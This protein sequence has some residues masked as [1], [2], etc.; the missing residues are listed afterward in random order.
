MFDRIYSITLAPAVIVAL[1]TVGG[2]FTCRL[3]LFWLRHPRHAWRAMRGTRG[4]GGSFRAVTMALAGTLGVGNI[5]GVA[6]ALLIGGPG[7]ILWMLLSAFAAMAVK[8]AEVLLAMDTRCGV[9]GNRTGGAT[10]YM[11][12]SGRLGRCLPRIF[13]A[14]CVLCALFQGSIIQGSAAGEAIC[15]SVGVKPVFAGVALTF[16]V[17]L[18]LLFGARGIG[19]VTSLAIPLATC[20][21]MGMCLVILLTHLT[22]IPAACLSVLKGAVSPAAGAGGVFGFLFSRAAREGCAKGL[23]SN[24]AGCGTAPMAHVTA[25]GTTPVGQALWGVFEVFL[26]TVVIC[27]LTA[28]ACLVV[29]PSGSADAPIAYLVSVFASVFGTASEYLTCVSIVIFAVSTTL[30]WAFYGMTCLGELTSSPVARGTYLVLYSF[31]LLIGC[32]VT[33]RLLYTLTDILL[34]LM[35]LINLAVLVKK[36]DRVVSLSLSENMISVNRKRECAPVSQHRQMRDEQC[37]PHTHA[38]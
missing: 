13:A 32:V 8:Y 31:S 19:R 1:L 7:A 11:R 33:P 12:F 14:L 36:R 20:L 35:T 6:L 27:S 15:I 30:T 4:I 21:Y 17:F 2:Y 3:R 38:R 18:V 9:A 34:A 5:A 29:S 28:L 24:E 16:I 37:S 22:D 10:R 26:D 25:E 23:F